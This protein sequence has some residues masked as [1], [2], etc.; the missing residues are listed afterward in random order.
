MVPDE[1]LKAEGLQVLGE[2]YWLRTQRE[3]E[4]GDGGDGPFGK[5]VV[6][7]VR[8]NVVEIGL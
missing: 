5:G 1:V 8:A 6:V 7:E 4:W 2:A 3:C